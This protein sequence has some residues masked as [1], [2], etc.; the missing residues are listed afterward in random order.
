M[1]PLDFRSQSTV[2]GA[3]ST[4]LDIVPVL[5]GERVLDLLLQALLALGQSLVPTRDDQPSEV[6]RSQA[7]RRS[8][9]LQFVKK[10][11]RDVTYLP[12]AILTSSDA[13][14]GRDVLL[15]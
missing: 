11:L 9:I 14:G 10:S 5:A 3:I 4:N 6:Y 1:Q 13:K 2:S 7:C 15:G 12:T 8:R